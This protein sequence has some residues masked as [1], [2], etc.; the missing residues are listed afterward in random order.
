MP[1]LARGRGG[2][3]KVATVNLAEELYVAKKRLGGLTKKVSLVEVLRLRDGDGDSPKKP[4]LR[5]PKK[6]GHKH[7][8]GSKARR[9]HDDGDSPKKTPQKAKAPRRDEDGASPKKELPI[10]RRR[11]STRLLGGQ[12]AKK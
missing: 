5:G 2:R 10:K 9:L 11:K 12:A 3:C 4:D 7:E 8:G 6:G 1:R